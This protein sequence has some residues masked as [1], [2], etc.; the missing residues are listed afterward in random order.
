MNILILE[1]NPAKLKELTETI[2]KLDETIKY[3]PC[4]FFNDLVIEINRTKYDLVIADL[5]VPLYSDNPNEE[6][7]VSD[8]L[9]EVIRD[10]DC[11]NF[12]TPVIAVTR[13][14]SLAE[15]N[16]LALNRCDINVITYDN[17]NEDWKPPFI[18]KIQSCIPIKKY[19]F[20]IICALE[21]EAKAYSEAGYNLGERFLSHGIT[22]RNI[23]IKEQEG[24]VITPTRMGLVNTAILSA[25]AIEL[26]KPKLICMSG[27]CAGIEG[28]ANIYDVIIPE[29]CHQHDS[30][31]WTNEG[32]IPELYDVPLDH[33]T[34]LKLDKIINEG[35][36]NDT[37]KNGITLRRSE[38][39]PANEELDFKV[40]LAPTSSG[41]AVVADDE[42]LKSIKIQHRK[43][44]AF[45][46][47][48]YAL[49]EAARQSLERPLFFSAK[50]VVD[51]GNSS[52]GDEYH[53]VAAIL[54]AKTVYEIIS[55]GI[56]KA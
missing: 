26:F 4:K 40:Y 45:E 55:R 12:K 16:F 19:D 15:E 46:M 3:K 41:S 21:K 37:L 38:F 2:T 34:S 23:S 50:A 28:K 10:I 48:S 6:V 13:F 53:R 44:T 22:C 18:N 33:Y 8:R 35:N 32:F 25:R 49:Y 51:N 36:F 9:L 1:D 30:G 29:M 52:K 14:D 11:I 27:I 20:I 39:Q 43:K 17:T 56:C 42:I 31:K 24:L 5:K 7:D 54:S 47:E